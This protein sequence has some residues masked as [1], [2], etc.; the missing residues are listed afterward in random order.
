MTDTDLSGCKQ[1]TLQMKQ[2]ETL[3]CDSEEDSRSHNHNIRIIL[4]FLPLRLVLLLVLLSF[5]V[6]LPFSPLCFPFCW[7]VRLT[8]LA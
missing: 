2:K 7:F 5:L 6:L 3:I 4:L 1:A 8:K